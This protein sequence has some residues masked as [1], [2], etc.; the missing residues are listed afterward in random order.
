[1]TKKQALPVKPETVEFI[2]VPVGKL[3]KSQ[4]VATTTVSRPQFLTALAAYEKAEKAGDLIGC[5]EPWCY[6]NGR[7]NRYCRTDNKASVKAKVEALKLDID[8][9][10]KE[11]PFPHLLK[12][13]Q[14][15]G[16]AGN[17]DELGLW[18]SKQGYAVTNSTGSLM[19]GKQVN[20]AEV[21]VK[22][23]GGQTFGSID[24]SKL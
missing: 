14:N 22:A 19:S 23:A 1:M 9:D 7:D 15:L 20:G 8:F 16:I 12:V 24:Y 4:P 10:N 18:L 2:T 3:P 11:H 6:L 5:V 13:A 21:V 17:R